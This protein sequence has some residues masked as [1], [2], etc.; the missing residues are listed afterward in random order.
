MRPDGCIGRSGHAGCVEMSAG[1]P[2]WCA[3]KHDAPERTPPKGGCLWFCHRS[4]GDAV[5]SCGR[6]GRLERGGPGHG[7]LLDTVRSAPDTSHVGLTDGSA[8][9][10]GVRS[11]QAA[12]QKGSPAN[13]PPRVFLVSRVSVVRHLRRWSRRRS[14]R[15]GLPSRSVAGLSPRGAGRRSESVGRLGAT[16]I[17]RPWARSSRWV[18]KPVDDGG[19]PWG[20]AVFPALHAA[21]VVCRRVVPGDRLRAF[22]SVAAMAGSSGG[23][24]W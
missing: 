7:G 2:P 23:T 5:L 10:H 1:P 22:G 13:D 4:G 9:I 3:V 11:V 14:L 15:L 24:S 16:A 21:D 6:S 18:R 19:G 20:S 12:K 17:W 8:C